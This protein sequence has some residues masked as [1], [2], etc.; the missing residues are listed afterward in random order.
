[1]SFAVCWQ[2]GGS[3]SDDFINGATAAADGSLFLVGDS[4][5]AWGGFTGSGKYDFAV[6]KLDGNGNLL[7]AWQASSVSFA[8]AVYL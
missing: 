8:A 7:W 3:Q 1:M 2:D 6:A 4:W 5:G